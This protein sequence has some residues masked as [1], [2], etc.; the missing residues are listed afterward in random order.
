M[1]VFE[2]VAGGQRA[3]LRDA[4]LHAAHEL[5]I[6]AGPVA[7]P[8]RRMR[9]L[10]DA[11]ALFGLTGREPDLAVPPGGWGNLAEVIRRDRALPE[12]RESLERFH[13]HL[14]EAGAEPARELWKALVVEGPLLDLG[15]GAGAYTAAFLAVFPGQQAT[16]ADRP[17]VLRLACAPGARLL[18][19]D[20]LNMSTPPV[21]AGQGAVLLANVLHLFG[22][23]QDVQFV[24]FAHSVL[25][26]GGTL[27]VKDL[28]SD[29]DEGVLFALNM[30][31]FTEE[32]DVHPPESLEKWVREAGF[33]DLR[34]VPLRTSPKSLVLAARK[35]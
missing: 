13:A 6:F 5:R 29:T 9:K 26:R 20:L 1:D 2:L 16:I 28:R 19:V 11:V 7:A 24:Q 31:L 33:V 35:P 18:E 8:T 12:D 10:L 4:V 23:A 27:I 32:G 17:E 25:R 14:L 22:P 15:G 30:A 3:Y 21:P 34:R